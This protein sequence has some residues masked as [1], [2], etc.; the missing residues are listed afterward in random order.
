MVVPC[1]SG[2]FGSVRASLKN[3]LPTLALAMKH[4]SPLRIHSSPWRS[5]LS[6]RPALGSAGGSRL[7]EPAL[8]SLIP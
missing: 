4:F 8:G 1:L 2:A 7:S 5:A 3:S 6:L